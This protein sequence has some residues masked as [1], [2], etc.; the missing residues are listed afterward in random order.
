M[1]P[2]TSRFVY[3]CSALLLC[4]GLDRTYPELLHHNV[5]MPSDLEAA[6]RQIFNEHEVPSDPPLY[7]VATTR[8]DPSQAPAGCENIFVLV[9]TPSQDLKHLI[10]WAVQRQ[11][12]VA[13]HS[14][15]AS[16]MPPVGIAR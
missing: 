1:H 8:T 15:A 3:S 13:I 7:V 6:C 14:A 2:R 5:L 16:P 9:P 4:L 12:S 10:D 11:G